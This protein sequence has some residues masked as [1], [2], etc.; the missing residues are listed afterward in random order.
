MIYLL[1]IFN[2]HNII[3]KSEQDLTYD[4]DRSKV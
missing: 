2:S 3:C 4:A 1:N